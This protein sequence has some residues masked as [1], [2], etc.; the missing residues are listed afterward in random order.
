MQGGLMNKKIPIM[1]CFDKNYVIPAAVAFYSLL[2]YANKKYKYI[3]YVLHSDI[4][5]SQQQKLC[6]T[7][8]EFDNCE[9]K[10]INMEHKLENEWKKSYR[11]D[12][13]SKE[14]MYK[15]LAASIF[16]QYDKLIISDVDVVFLGDIS[17]SY[18]DLDAIK[19]DAYIAGVKP[20]G[21]VKKYFENYENQWS[22]E[23]I[24][25]LGEICGG[26]LV[27]NLK[28]IREDN[29][30]KKFM[31]SLKDNSHRL[32]Q[33]E[34]DILNLVCYGKIKH[35]HLKYVACSYMWDYYQTEKDMETDENYT[36][37]EIEEALN[38]PVQLHYATSIKPWKNVDCTKSDIWFQFIVKTPFL[39]DYLKWLPNNIVVPDERI[40]IINHK[41]NHSKFT[42]ILKYIKRNPLFFIKK[43]FYVKVIKYGKRK[44]K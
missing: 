26:Y 9:I 2:Q 20:I 4:N 37:D 21:E 43:D 16:P 8:K 12:H 13:F 38:H 22:S 7:I 25:K 27:M 15:L 35:L 42:R 34:Q 29:I 33:M 41:G 24:E 14:V 30:E 10:F 40:N 18:F 1:F 23:E 19:D 6:E 5:D 3:F 32:N 36:K 39:E 11:G 31:K 44:F 28:K 17:E